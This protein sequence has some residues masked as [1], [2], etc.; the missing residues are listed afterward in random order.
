M[1][2]LMKRKY[3]VEFERVETFAIDVLAK[4]VDTAIELAKKKL[5]ELDEGGLLHYQKNE[6]NEI[7]VGSV[8]DVTD[9]D[10]PFNE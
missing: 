7:E 10:D 4:D 3:K 2:D 1:K 5:G 9:T 8:Y 6:Y